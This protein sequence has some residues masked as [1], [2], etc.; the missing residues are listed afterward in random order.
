MTAFSPRAVAVAIVGLFAGT[1]ALAADIPTFFDEGKA[2]ATLET[3][4][5]KAKHPTKVLSVDIRAYEFEVEVQDPDSPKHIDGW[6]DEIRTSGVMRYISPEAIT[7]PSPVEPTLVN[8]DLEGNLFNLKPSDLALVHQL[9]VDAAARAR[10]EDPVR[11]AR[12]LLKRQLFLVPAASSGPPEWSVEI[13][14]GRESATI[15]ADMSGRI[16]HANFDGTRRAQTLNYLNGGKELDDVVAMVADAL[17][18]DRIIKS[19]IVYDKS[20]GFVATNPDHP[21]R[22][23]SFTAGIN[24]VYQ[25][26]LDTPVNVN[27]PNQAPPGR[28]A[29]TDIDWSILPKLQ[30][31]ARDQLLLP[32]GRIA[33]VKLSKPNAGVN[34]PQIEWEINVEAANDPATQGYVTF[35]VNGKVLHTRY[36]PGKGPKLDMLDAASIAPAFDAL[37]QALGEH[38][39]MT[40]LEFRDERLMLTTRDP[41]NPDERL[42]FEYRGEALSRSI[43]APLEWPTFGPDWFF[44]LSQARPVV[45]HWADM[46]KDALSRLGLAD[47]KIERVTISKQKL[48][49]PHNDRILVEVRAESGKR[50]GRVV[51]D[52]NGKA[53]DI[54]M[55]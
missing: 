50:S 30:Q 54:V 13:S 4:F 51:Y 14:S 46:E 53:V 21:D 26:V 31:A 8:P 47:G 39:A 41:K 42:V 11:D 17:G 37:Q 29:I 7:G 10:L 48:F 28:F 15:Y 32:G 6:T 1:P 2:Q 16:T 12:L 33:L 9:I 3:I 44:D 18:K 40:E 34:G 35:D 27:I 55:P 20:L 49:M 24:G 22:D 43:M 45:D 52:L 19:A 23:A 5:D 36:P 25:V 38:A